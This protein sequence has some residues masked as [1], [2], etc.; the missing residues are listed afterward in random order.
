MY[1]HMYEDI[2]LTHCPSVAVVV[3]VF[4]AADGIEKQRTLNAVFFFPAR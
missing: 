2:I 4:V 3:V 1:V